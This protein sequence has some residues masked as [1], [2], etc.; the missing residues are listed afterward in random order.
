M[1]IARRILIIFCCFL[2]V[3]MNAQELRETTIV[4]ETFDVS[5][6]KKKLSTYSFFAG[7]T[8]VVTIEET[9]G[10]E[11]FKL[12]I[13]DVNS[14]FKKIAKK[15][16]VIEE[17][18]VVATDT[19]FNFIFNQKP[20]LNALFGFKRNIHIKIVKEEYFES[21]VIE[22]N[23]FVET[24]QVTLYDTSVVLTQSDTIFSP[25]VNEFIALGSIIE[26]GKKNRKTIAI[27]PVSGA[28]YYVYW[29]GVGNKAKRDYEQMKVKMPL[30]WSALGVIEPI[31]AFAMGKIRQMPIQPEGEDVYFALADEN[32]KKLFE[33]QQKINARFEKKGV[34]TYGIIDTVNIPEDENT[35]I[36]LSN[37][38]AISNIGVYIKITAVIINDTYEEIITDTL[39]T[40]QNVFRLN[41]EAMTIAEAK[42]E[43]VRKEKEL[44]AAWIR[45]FE[46]HE[47][48]QR[49]LDSSWIARQSELQQAA[50]NLEI[51]WKEVEAKEQTVNQV[52][53]A[54]I[55]EKLI[56]LENPD[57]NCDSLTVA[58]MRA[59]LEVLLADIEMA[60]KQLR[61]VERQRKR[62]N[63]LMQQDIKQVTTRKAERVVDDA[64]R[65]AANAAGKEVKETIIESAEKAKDVLK[66]GN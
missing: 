57:E 44:G 10:R 14:P 30:E 4:D 16:S 38:N 22:I 61:D 17:R 2:F 50:V 6:F 35:F 13:E 37:D 40:V 42:T 26:P 55:K 56:A 58:T 45:A 49:A 12:I 33:V 51:S 59:E 43:I 41:T 54:Q 1:K 19:D 65:K 25:V 27:K 7:D 18:I 64:T 48:A 47:A 62:L 52:I 66:G 24:T 36:C 46:E 63:A 11:L 15:Q 20:T 31:E 23:D 60:K 29:I 53:E 34:V 5:M 3:T 28:T 21:E 39:I 9:K 8:I 32:D